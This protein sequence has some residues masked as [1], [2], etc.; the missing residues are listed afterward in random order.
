MQWKDADFISHMVQI[1]LAIEFIPLDPEILFISH[2]VQIIH[3]QIKLARVLQ[4]AAL[5]PTWF[6]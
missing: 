5:Y 1:I 6:R 2:M 3:K 4:I